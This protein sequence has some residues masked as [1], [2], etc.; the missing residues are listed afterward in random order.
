MATRTDSFD[1][2]DSTSLGGDWAEDSGDWAIVSNNVRNGTT[3]SSYRKL[4]WVG[5]AMDSSD[6]AVEAPCRSGSDSHAVGPAARMAASSTVTYYGLVIFAGYGAYLVYIN[7]GAETVLASSSGLTISSGTTYTLRLEVEGTAIRGYVDGTLRVSATHSALT[8]GPPGLAGYGGNNSGTYA[9][10]WS[11][12]DL[13]G[14]ASQ[15]D[16]SDTAAGSDALN[17][18]AALGLADAGSG[19]DAPGNLAASLARTDAGSGVDVLAQVLAALGLADAGSGVDVLGNLAA[20]VPVGD[21]GSGAD[22]PGVVVTLS[23]SDA[24]GGVD[25]LALLT[26]AIKQ[27]ADSGGGAD[28][29][30]PPG[31]VLAVVDAGSGA[32]SPGVMVALS[33]SDAGSAAELI[34]V[35]AAV[36][37]SV[38]DAGSAA[39]AVTVGVAPF[40]V[41]DSGGGVDAPGVAVTLSVSDAAVGDDALLTAMLVAVADAAAAVDGVGSIAVHAP[42]SDVAQAAHVIGAIAATLAVVDLG[43]GVDVAIAFDAALRIVRVDFSI[44]RRSVAFA[45]LAR[46]LTCG[47]AAREIEFSMVGRP[48]AFGFARRDVSFAWNR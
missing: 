37:V 7:N 26:E 23:V 29:V 3:G 9:T 12:A 36:L 15:I 10:Q 25:V 17:L 45:W 34:A 47:W 46:S 1:R 8:A 30:L 24:G 18:A 44:A 13:G 6:Y 5:A 33:V 42:V 43:A 48:V 4:R 16:V 28:A 32:D 38:L 31:V 40:A 2:S 41:G 19:V 21:S 27:V 35:L 20:S 39:E 11:A 22:S 14:G